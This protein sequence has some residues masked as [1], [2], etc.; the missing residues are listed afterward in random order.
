MPIVD[1]V[2]AAVRHQVGILRGGQHDGSVLAEILLR[3]HP[4]AAGTHV[5]GTRPMQRARGGARRAVR[6]PGA[7]PAA[8]PP[9][10]AT[11]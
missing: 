9:R 11:R 8:R 7:R 2:Q 6:A 4:A 3:A 10:T 1:H 5:S